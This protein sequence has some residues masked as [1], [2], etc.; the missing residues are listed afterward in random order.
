MTVVSVPSKIKKEAKKGGDTK[1]Q[2]M[3]ESVRY[4]VAMATV[5]LARVDVCVCVVLNFVCTAH[6]MNNVRISISFIQLKRG[7][8]FLMLSE[9]TLI[10][11]NRRE[12]EG[13]GPRLQRA[14]VKPR[15]L[16]RTQ[17]IMIA[18]IFEC[19]HAEGLQ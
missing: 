8:G 15:P 14:T 4:S 12:E 11:C 9:R 5:E 1:E 17:Y 10:A 2:E 3:R 18:A 6:K 16:W 13:G 7:S 19:C